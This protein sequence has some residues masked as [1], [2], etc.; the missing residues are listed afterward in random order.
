[1]AIAFKEGYEKVYIK[2]APEISILGEKYGPFEEET[3]ELP[4]SVALFL[5]CRKSARVVR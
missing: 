2:R 4:L 1:M 3:Q 5:L